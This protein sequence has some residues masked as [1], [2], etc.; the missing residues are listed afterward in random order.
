MKIKSYTVKQDDVVRKFNTFDFIF[1]LEKA[2]KD[3]S[4]SKRN[5]KTSKLMANLLRSYVRK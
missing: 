5:R 2:A 1:E 3:K 4:R